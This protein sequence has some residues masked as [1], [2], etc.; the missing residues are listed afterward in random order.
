VA[1][2]AVTP[3]EEASDMRFVRL[4]VFPVVVF[5]TALPLLAQV[6]ARLMRYPAV[7]GGQIA[8]EYG[9]DI[10][11]GPKSGGTAGRLTSAKGEET[12]PRFSP[13]GSLVAFTASYDGNPDVY[14]IPA[15]GG[16][17]KR[18]TSH[19]APDRP[20][21]W[22][23]DG[24][25][26][27]VASSRE[28]GRD[29]FDQLFKV[30]LEGGL[31]E[32]L[33]VPYGEFGALSPDGKTLAFVPNSQDFR[34]WKRY[35][36]GWVSRTYLLGLESHQSRRVGD[37]GASYSQPMWHGDTL[38]VLS[39]RDA[40]KRNNIWALDL[41][42][43]A[44]R[45]VTFFEKED[46]H[47]PSAGPAD[48]VF[49][50]GGQIYLLDLGTEKYPPV[51]I[52]VVTDFS[53]LKP[54]VQKVADL[55]GSF[56]VSPTGKRAVFEARGDV[57]SVPAEEGAVLDLTR[58]SG[59]AERSPAWSPDGK[60][61][62][63]WSDRSGEYE[64]TLRP[65][66][67]SGEEHTVTKLGPGFRYSIFWS[68]DSAKVLFV[69]QAMNVNLCDVSTGNVTRVDRG[70]YLY[71]EIQNDGHESL[72]GFR[73]S[74]SPDSRFAAWSR[75]DE[76][77]SGVIFVY[78]TQA[79]KTS[80]LTSGFY[81]DSDPVFDPEGKY[82]FY[83]TKR[84]FQAAYGLDGTW[85]YANLTRLA[86]VPLRADG[87]SPLPVK[88][89]EEKREPESRGAG[90]PEKRKE[91]ESRGAGEPE[92]KKIEPVKIDLE[93]FE[94]RAVL[95]PPK[96]GNYADLAA[97][98]GKVIYRRL[99]RTGSG[100]EK[101]PIAYFDLKERE[102]K[103]V[104]DDAD[105]YDLAAGAERLLAVKKK[106]YAVIDVKPDQKMD[107]KLPTSELEMTVDPRAEWR[108]IFADAWRFER[109][110]F[111]DPNMH[112][113]DWNEM[114]ARYGAL[115]D[116]CATR[117]D[118]NFV[119]GELIGELN[120]SHAYRG[121]GQAE[122]PEKREG[123]LL[124]C[125][126]S[127]ESGAYRIKRI[128]TAA[129]WDAEPRSPLKEPGTPV[130]EG[131]Y[132]LAVNGAKVDAA[133]DPWSA[134]DGMAGQTAVLT[135][136]S[137]PQMEGARQ[138]V[139]KLMDLGAEERLRYLVWVEANRQKVERATGGRIGYI[140]VPDTGTDGQDELYRQFM[141]QYKK[142]GLIIDERFN[143]GGQI[144]DRF[145]EML[146]R[147]VLNYWAARDGVDWQWPPYSCPGPKVMLMNEWSGSGGD[148]FP[149]YFKMEKVG[150]LIG[151]RT[152]GGL[153]GISGSPSLV[154]GGIVTVP[155]FAMYSADGRWLV[156]GH[157]VDPDIAVEDDPAKMMD[158]GDP[159]LDR[160]V[161][162]ALRLL[163]EKPAPAPH[164]PAYEDRSGK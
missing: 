75:E 2:N 96:A 78:D 110:F 20:V 124:G 158:G 144:P 16:L 115:I 35:R 17:P 50:A 76:R 129:P 21:G 94:A 58:S 114:R 162:E 56:S 139:V 9:G 18:L 85:I 163:K 37:D 15:A 81:Y 116:Q 1:I 104:L 47:L 148:C 10:W 60:W 128:L 23:P 55:I 44:L 41:K 34:T 109:D 83:L 26:V 61:I 125:D 74:W 134:L 153:I 45:Q 122:K 121:G 154:D 143:S 127:L 147:P 40:N 5:L 70:L 105:A 57:F 159:Q 149:F 92:K 43:G 80:R 52:R 77:Q 64:L 150:P 14:V 7:S 3:T 97:V 133:K 88:N 102:E 42:S 131:D 123:G 87:E 79:Q 113:V 141:G 4:R 108:Q 145:V 72:M 25:A 19:P 90:E 100:E 39:D 140:Y 91:S 99:P 138:A 152:W 132:L 107:K 111:Y 126:F 86:A 119:L 130:R 146:N 31:P 13:D 103:T 95:L 151:R 137:R 98:A 27:L 66:D 161:E 22:T 84:S 112:R 63:Y 48:I 135:V 71:H 93:G 8:F 30:P 136:N 33:P 12:F 89:D 157:G 142:E 101:S 6:D 68:P 156:E 38:Y 28:S 54:S 59:S 53:M 51:A 117:W 11:V 160:A 46:V 65:G 67:G 62:A 164:R 155:T 24:K 32:K 106:D 69:D 36:G 29:R 120:S 49:Q 73:A 118:V 82:L